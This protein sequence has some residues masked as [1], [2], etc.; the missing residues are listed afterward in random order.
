MNTLKIVTVATQSNY[1]FPYLK[2]SVERNG[3]ELVVLGSGEEW[4]GF[5]WRYQLVIEYLKTTNK[6]DIVCFV[7]GYDIICCRNLNKLTTDFLKLKN[8]HNCK[9]IVGE[10]KYYTSEIL[11]QIMAYNIFNGGTCKEKFLNSGTY[12]G[13]SE[14]ILDVI[15]NIYTNSISNMDDDQLLMKKYC[16]LNPHD[17]YIDVKSELFLTIIKP[18][19][20]IDD[21][22][23]IEN[24]KLRYK[25]SEPYFI[26]GSSNT[27]LDNILL[28][29]GYKIDN[30]IR[31]K[32]KDDF[33]KKYSLYFSPNIYNKYVENENYKKY[34]VLII[35]ILIII[36]SI[37]I[38]GYI[39]KKYYKKILKYIA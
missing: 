27:Y 30:T 34:Y 10:D 7:D 21:L 19:S 14:D 12:I 36:I 1:Y 39:N 33:Y 18:Y 5:N 32:L 23:H 25:N 31:N 15:I 2:E 16:R 3:G 11:K 17:F 8:T 35:L 13:F 9:I 24:G 22:V 29:L 26:H 20:E 6:T 38:Y 37:L 4:H 28:K